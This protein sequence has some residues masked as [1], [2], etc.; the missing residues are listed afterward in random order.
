MADYG[1]WTG[2]ILRVDLST[3]VISKE[4]TSKYKDYI[5]GVGLGYKILWDEVPSGTKAWDPANRIIFGVGPLSGT[6]A[7]L[8]G[9][10]SVISLWPVHPDELPG[11]GHMGGHWGAELKFAGYDSL[12]IQGKAAKPSWIYIKDDIV[13]IRDAG[14]MWG[15]GIYRATSDI[16]DIMGPEAQV[17]AIGQCGENLVR[18]SN[19]MT[20]R[21]HSAG[22]VGSVMGSKNLKAIG[23]IGTGG[24]KIAADKKAW[25]DLVH[26][27]HTILGA[28]SGGVVPN[29]FQAWQ[30]D[31]YYG[32]TRW[33]AA[34]GL[35]WGAAT[36]P[37]H[38]GECTADDLNSI[39][40]RTF[41]GY[42]DF[43]AG[44]GDKHTVKIGG[45]H[46][47]PIRCHIATD[48]PALETKYG[49][50]RYQV[51]TCNG[52][53]SGS[54]FLMNIPS[55]SEANI[56]AS[57]LGVALADDYGFWSD[58]GQ[59]QRVFQFFYTTRIVVDANNPA[60]IP[61]PANPG[62]T[63]PNPDI[64]KRIWEK[65]LTTAEYNKVPWKLLN[66]DHPADG[67]KASDPAF[68]LTWIPMLAKNLM[69]DGTLAT[70]D[71]IQASTLTPKTKSASC[72]ALVAQG[73]GRL[74][75]LIPE[76]AQ[77]FYDNKA[78]TNQ[79]NKGF[80]KHH[81]IESSGMGQISAL[82][83][84]MFNRDPMCHTHTNYQ[85]NGLPLALQN[86]I[87]LDLFKDDGVSG[88]PLYAGTAITPMNKSKAV[89]A[90]LSLLYLQ[91]HDS[92]TLCNY[93]LPGWASPLKSRNYRG[94]AAMEALMYSAV[95]GET[96]TRKQ[97]E[98]MGI[99]IL[100]LFR[101]LNARYMNEKDQR[102][103][104]DII[105]EWAFHPHG[106]STLDHADME[107]AKDMLYDEFGWDKA[108]GMP[109]RATF[110]R[111][112]MKDVADDLAARGLLP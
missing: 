4:D 107:L 61:D 103:K 108:T 9:R 69:A 13:E 111:L 64:G 59:I 97:L 7:P 100:S 32:G 40:L 30:P 112:N 57:Q 98:D 81:F 79:I 44:V 24:I 68:L 86:E 70:W 46:S 83:N 43:G 52:N 48:V 106:Y 104:H 11:S 92:L 29:T 14:R 77:E 66:P 71:K 55:R 101:A 87:F 82:I 12:I 27:Q 38:T 95:T 45:C 26:Y 50:S 22:G 84:M 17:A 35:Y 78:G 41:K 20:G 18:V 8:S 60:T 36:P 58:Y 10:V 42:A 94:E 33:T 73:P 102:N 109:T 96:V 21:S 39:G 16:L 74:M 99:R 56:E 75:Q 25:K 67:T 51:N 47:C 88:D 91:L 23:V 49:V 72:A 34:N 90:K 15:N 2:K 110:E 93:T 65:Y 80:V 89:Y 54:G 105:P 6:G 62:Q 37:V 53:S 63:I 76:L 28:N 85:G 5:G 19:V 31:G 3:G 1:G